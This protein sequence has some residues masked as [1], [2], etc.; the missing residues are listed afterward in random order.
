ML[1]SKQHREAL[2]GELNKAKEDKELRQ[3]CMKERKDDHLKEWWEIHIFLADERIKLIEKSLIE[4]EI[5]Y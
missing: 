1:L 2:L 5:D 3:L 4:N